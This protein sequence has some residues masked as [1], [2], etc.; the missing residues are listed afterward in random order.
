MNLITQIRIKTLTSLLHVHSCL[1]RE[2][3]NNWFCH[4]NDNGT[5][6]HVTNACNNTDYKTITTTH[7]VKSDLTTNN[8]KNDNGTNLNQIYNND[9]VSNL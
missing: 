4:D 2:I 8:S 5:L 1:K 7:N 6:L 3:N 9:M